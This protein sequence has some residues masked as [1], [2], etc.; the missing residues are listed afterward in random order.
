MNYYTLFY[1]TLIIFIIFKNIIFEK[2]IEFNK[3]NNTENILNNLNLNNI[4][5]KYILIILL[6]FYV[7]YKS[8]LFYKILM[9]I[10]GVIIYY[11]YTKINFIL[12]QFK[13]VY[14]NQ[15]L[16]NKFILL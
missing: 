15:F 3:K 6:S 2:I 8:K 11:N 7:I 14:H 4:N 16:I 12:N 9:L 5:R 1:L 13:N 10:C